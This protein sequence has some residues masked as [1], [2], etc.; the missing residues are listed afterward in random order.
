[1]AS[2]K[3]TVPMPTVPPNSQPTSSTVSS[4]PVR[5]SR[6]ERPVTRA[7]PVISPSRGPGPR[8]APMYMPVATPHS[9]TPA[10]MQPIL[11]AHPETRGNVARLT[12][13]D[14]PTSTTLLTVP[15]PGRCRSGIQNSRTA[16]PTMMVRVPI[17]RPACRARPWWKTSHGSRP[18][19]E[20]TCR[21]PDRPYSHSPTYS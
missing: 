13:I 17:S 1:M 7:R 8:C 14:S 5:H 19:P 16:A 4:M 6:I 3:T 18:S 9:S 11:A 21:A 20:R 2:A 10:A 15:T 12:F